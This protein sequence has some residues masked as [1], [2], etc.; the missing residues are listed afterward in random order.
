[1]N[2]FTPPPDGARLAP[3]AER[4][5]WLGSLAIAYALPKEGLLWIPGGRLEERTAFDT[6]SMRRFDADAQPR[7]ESP[8]ASPVLTALHEIWAALWL[9]DDADSWHVA[10]LHYRGLFRVVQIDD[11]THDW[12]EARAAVADWASLD[13]GGSE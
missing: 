1:M 11:T 6:T 9:A 7:A 13:S 10:L 4:A 3:L 12:F 5:R 8:L 2:P